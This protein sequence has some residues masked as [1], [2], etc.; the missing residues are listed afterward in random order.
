MDDCIFC[1]I[2]KKEIPAEIV[3][4]DEHVLAFLDIQP[5]APGHT[6]VIPKEHAPDLLALEASLI[7][8]TFEA[9]RLVAQKIS[10]ALNPE[11]MIYGINQGQIAGHAGVNHLHVHILPRFPGD[12][13]GPI[14]I[15]VNNPPVEDVK[16]IAEKIR[17]VK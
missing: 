8:P 7:G 6:M 13:G 17:R 14:Q 1:K 9:V 5:R 2:V 3:Y 4:E 10:R 12:D 11:G 16:S 15:V